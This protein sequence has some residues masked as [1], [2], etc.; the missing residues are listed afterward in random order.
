MA[1]SFRQH[2]R[3][4]HGADAEIVAVEQDGSGEPARGNATAL[5]KLVLLPLYLFLIGVVLVIAGTTTF[6]VGSIC[7]ALFGP[8]I[9]AI[10]G[11]FMGLVCLGAIV[12]GLGNLSQRP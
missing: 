10:A 6:I 11:I 8:V 5:K 4:L 12:S 2:L 9:G 7:W 3:E 1:G